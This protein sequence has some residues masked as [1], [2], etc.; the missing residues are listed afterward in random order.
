M[1][2]QHFRGPSA[3]TPLAETRQLR[4]T[5]AL[6]SS[7]SGE[8]VPDLSPDDDDDDVRY[9]RLSSLARRRHDA[10]AAEATACAAAGI[11]ALIGRREGHGRTAAARV[12]AVRLRRSLAEIERVL[13]D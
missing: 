6:L 5:L 3:A 8:P 9:G 13:A 10:L 12:L 11:A 1:T 7:L 2:E 4:A